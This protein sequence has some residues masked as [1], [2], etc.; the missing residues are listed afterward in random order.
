MRVTE[1]RNIPFTNQVHTIRRLGT[2]DLQRRQR[3]IM[4]VAICC[5]RI[6]FR[7]CVRHP[8]QSLSRHYDPSSAPCGHQ[9]VASLRAASAPSLGRHWRP[10]PPT[11]RAAAAANCKLAKCRPEF[12]VTATGWYA[13]GR[14]GAAAAAQLHCVGAPRRC[15]RPRDKGGVC[16]GTGT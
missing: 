3:T 15:R 10:C 14:A 9:I 1:Y 13:R 7:H 11:Q 6:P 4:P 2:G 8:L 16:G 5:R 12:S